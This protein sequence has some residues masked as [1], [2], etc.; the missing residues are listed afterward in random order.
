[1]PRNAL[2]F[3]AKIRLRSYDRILWHMCIR[4]KSLPELFHDE[5]KRMLR[6]GQIVYAT[7]LAITAGQYIFGCKDDTFTYRVFRQYLRSVVKID[8]KEWRKTRNKHS[9]DLLDGFRQ[10]LEYGH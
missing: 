6:A 8:T 5:S 7:K 2:A 3:E 4:D 1:M 9:F 10:I